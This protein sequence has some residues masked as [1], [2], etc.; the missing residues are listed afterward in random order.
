[1][2][3]CKSRHLILIG[4]LLLCGTAWDRASAQPLMAPAESAILYQLG[5]GRLNNGD[6]LRQLYGLRT[7][8]RGGRSLA[9]D[10]IREQN[11]VA[12]AAAEQ[13]RI[14]QGFNSGLLPRQPTLNDRASDQQETAEEAARQAL[15][16]DIELVWERLGGFFRPAPSELFTSL[17]PKFK[18][19]M[20]L[21]AIRVGGPIDRAGWQVDTVLIGLDKYKTETTSDIAYVADNFKGSEL[22]FVVLKNGVPEKGVLP[23]RAEITQAPTNNANRSPIAT[24]TPVTKDPEVKSTSNASTPPVPSKEQTPDKEPTRVTPSPATVAKT[25]DSQ[26][27]TPTTEQSLSA[28]ELIWQVVGVRVERTDVSAIDNRFETGLKILALNPDGV[29]KTVGW[30]VN[31][32]LLA[33]DVFQ[34]KTIDDLAYIASDA[35]SYRDQSVEFRLLRGKTLKAGQVALDYSSQK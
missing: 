5:T 24:S 8:Q 30:Q 35:A 19:G 1:M 34:V 32:I 16:E 17:T 22:K 11:A 13:A 26:K 20:K 2:Y 33:L 3:C 15:T 4:L 14:R 23:L 10:S 28:S 7:L 27:T 9:R 21:A 25:A 29:A 6:F 12:R 18:G 31:D